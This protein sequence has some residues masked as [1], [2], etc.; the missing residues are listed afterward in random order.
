MLTPN[1]LAQSISLA[2]LFSTIV[3]LS[4]LQGQSLYFELLDQE[5]GLSDEFNAYHF[6]DSDQ[7]LWLSGRNGLNR[8]DG[9][10]TKVYRPAQN[11]FTVDP[12]VTSTLFEDTQKR[13][14]FTANNA[15]GWVD[16]AK[17][18]LN[19][20]QLSNYKN[21]YYHAFYLERDSFLWMTVDSQLFKLS[22]HHLDPATEPLMSY[23]GFV[24]Y[25][26]TDAQG[27]V[28]GLSR[29]L[30]HLDG[31][32]EVLRFQEG[33]RVTRDS[34]FVPNS[35]LESPLDTFIFYFH[36]END[37]SFWLPSSAGL[38]HFNPHKPSERKIYK[39]L[40]SPASNVNL[41]YRDL[42]PWK[43]CFFW[44]ISSVGELLLFDKCNQVFLRC[45]NTF[46]VEN[47]T[48]KFSNF[49]SLYIDSKDHLWISS[50]YEGVLKTNLN[51]KS[52]YQLFP[53]DSLSGQSDYPINSMY[54]D[55]KKGS[56][57]VLVDN[58]GLYELQ[59]DGLQAYSMSKINLSCCSDEDI[60][61]IFQDSS[62]D[63][64]IMTDERVFLWDR[65]ANRFTPKVQSNRLAN[66]MIEINQGEYLL[67]D[68][69]GLYAFSKNDRFFK[70][71]SKESV[72]PSIR[73]RAEVYFDP[74][75]KLIFVAQNNNQLRVFQG[76]DPFTEIRTFN[77]LG[78]VN[79][80][81]TSEFQQVIWLASSNGLYKYDLTRHEVEKL[82]ADN[83]VLNLNLYSVVEDADRQLWLGTSWGIY[84]WDIEAEQ[85]H[86]FDRSDGLLTM[87]YAE[88]QILKE[89]NG[90]IYLGGKDGI[91]QVKPNELSL[92]LNPPKIALRAVWVKDKKQDTKRFLNFATPPTFSSSQNSLKLVF[93]SIEHTAPADNQYEAYLI[94]NQ[95]DTIS[96]NETTAFSLLNLQPGEYVLDCYS[97][98]NDGIRSEPYQIYFKINAPWYLSNWAIILWVIIILNIFYHWNQYR[99][100]LV[101]K[102]EGEKRRE[103]EYKQRE[104]EY[105]QLVAETKTAVLR[106]QMNPHFIF[107]SMNS[108]SS[109]LIQ[110]DIET[111][112]DYL[113]RFANLMRK[114]LELA[115]ESLTDITEEIAFLTLYLETE[116][117]RLKGQLHYSF[118]VDEQI[119][120]ED[121]LI[122]TIVLQ[123]FVENA[124]WHGISPKKGS[125][126]IWIRF[127]KEKGLLVCEVEDDGVGRAFHE[128][129]STIHDSKAL[130]IT[131]KRLN[132][133]SENSGSLA[134]FKITDLYH[135]DGK[136]KGT[137]VMLYLPLL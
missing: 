111:A 33:G 123:P 121:T 59:S 39:H 62:D 110:K 74:V 88:N 83:D 30:M 41:K 47:Q 20:F 24:V 91:T 112:N 56:L 15:V 51:N 57:L 67:S 9:E 102:K 134:F 7:F 77:N 85:L 101:R 106:L 5:N 23:S 117:M 34:F 25:P 109:Y 46:F 4:F 38:I 60:N 86:Y 79:G 84:K 97:T 17:D 81:F 18:S 8:F 94:R 107:N 40:G 104:A 12:N 137:K 66:K 44:L 53:L 14:W 135:P 32:I 27:H 42:V 115:E 126:H 108:I 68:F 63:L 6:K 21:S 92:N 54:L 43:S 3:C 48:K 99:V 128:K 65:T 130:K 98:N 132:L 1:K 127:R 129:L 96:K 37:S 36:I 100:F 13:K 72:I 50:F 103:A 78:L 49:N 19:Y 64:W 28:T 61:G 70:L 71:D 95:Q 93:S 87:R 75:N 105:K 90:L 73:M 118:E 55:G 76:K 31:G 58:K 116:A 124:I 69:N 114:I 80:F 45:Q 52:F 16:D 133:L 136:A 11:N 119:D 82:G 122:P 26:L 125:G 29:P 113:H 120:T 10:Q 2:A 35:E 22:I 89:H 131:R